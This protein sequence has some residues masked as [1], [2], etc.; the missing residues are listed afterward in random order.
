M[1]E[2]F[3]SP[4]PRWSAGSPLGYIAVSGVV[5]VIGPDGKLR[6]WTNTESISWVLILAMRM[7]GNSWKAK[8]ATLLPAV[9]IWVVVRAGRGSSPHRL[10]PRRAALSTYGGGQPPI[11]TWSKAVKWA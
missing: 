5:S 1:A 9:T 6:I 4:P 2:K 10:S 3:L 7:F 8:V 11:A